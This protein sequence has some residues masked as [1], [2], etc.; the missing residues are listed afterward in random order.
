MEIK[1]K[2]GDTK[3]KISSGDM[4]KKLNNYSNTFDRITKANLGI[5]KANLDL[6]TKFY[7]NMPHNLISYH[8]EF[9]KVFEKYLEAGSPG[10][11]TI[12][13][14]PDVLPANGHDIYNYVSRY[15]IGNFH[16]QAILEFDDKLDFD[17]LTRAVR[18]S[19]DAEPVLGCRFVEGNPPY[20]K[21]LDNLDKVKFTSLEEVSDVAPAIQSFLDRPL[22][23][24]KD[25]KIK[26]NLIRSVSQDV[27][28]IKANHA[29]CDGTGIKEY[30]QLLSYLYS[31]IDSPSDEIISKPGRR[32]RKDQD[33]LFEVFRISDPDAF[34]IPGSD[35]YIPTW[36]F[37]WKQGTSNSTHIVMCRLPQEQLDKISSYAKARGA[38]INDLILTAYYRA[39]LRMGQPVY[40]VPM[41]INV[42]IDLRRYL[43]DKKTE[44]IRNFSGS[45]NTW[46]SMVENESF[47]DTLSRVSYMMNEVKNGYPG[48]QSAI[49]LERL[50][51]ISFK[52]TLAYYQATSKVGKNMPDCPAFY[53]NRC[54]PALSNLGVISKQLIKFGDANVVDYFIIPP[55]VSA[56]GLLMVACTYN[57]VLTLAAGYYE[58]TVLREDIERLLNSMKDELLEGISVCQVSAIDYH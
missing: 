53:G 49:G 37:P 6:Y 40:G 5:T 43:P 35:I 52:D 3:F 17:R 34:W 50:E 11:G 47:G 55:V 58:K 10:I 13:D 48:L 4:L 44:A 54:I 12:P 32:G 31:N 39:M 46:I 15:G 23:M 28:A 27:L 22:D 57:D 29:C 30:I 19:V 1:F 24:D 45:A 36:A 16:S 8:K 14:S 25:P 51:K 2:L 20:W 38:T 42:T 21:R 26:I 41:G 18:M 33:R 56:P 7:D 9:L